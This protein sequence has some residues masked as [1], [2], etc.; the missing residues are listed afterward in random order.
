[1]N[2]EIIGNYVDLIVL[3][4]IEHGAILDGDELGDILLPKRYTPT[5][6]SDGMSIHVFVYFDSE[7]RI[8]ATTEKPKIMRNQF[9]FLDVK[10]TNRVGAFMD[11]GL[12]KDLLVPFAE[13]KATLQE[14]GNYLV[15][16][17]F[18]SSSG[19]LVGSS[20]VEKFLNNEPPE[21]THNEEVKILVVEEHRL[22]YKVIVNH[23]YQ[24]MLYAS[25]TFSPIHVGMQCSAFVKKV[26]DDFK[27]DLSLQ[28]D[29][30]QRVEDNE[31][32]ILQFLKDNGKKMD[33]N[34]KTDPQ[35]IYAHF[36][37]SKK[38]FKKVIGA[39]YKARKIRI[40]NDMIYLN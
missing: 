34:D 2:T 5:N 4:I 29:G 33:F 25:D 17:Y 36:E 18:D 19:R 8:V 20:K 9:A 38:T 7:D 31:T 27:I 13:Q 35:T 37:M 16:C 23:S 12:A 28:A 21:L 26:R 24:G 40:E 32:K 11:W 1:M 10:E 22:G 14:E 15:F 3:R 39:L 6:L 30:Y